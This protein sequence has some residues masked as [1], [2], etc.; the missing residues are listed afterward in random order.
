MPR[1]PPTLLGVY[2]TV[3]TIAFGGLLL[4]GARSAPG[5]AEFDTISVHRINVI[6]PDGTLR[7][8]ISDH[9]R[10]P[11]LIVHGKEYAHARPQAGMLFFNDEG[12]EQGGLV[13][14]GG[15]DKEA[16]PVAS[17]SRSTATSR[18]SN[19]S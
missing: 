8:V 17:A 6:E 2:A 15:R 5:N 18:T 19:C 14:A 9:A 7:M 13:F 10:F 16:I 11:G 4:M 3:L 12:T 1:L